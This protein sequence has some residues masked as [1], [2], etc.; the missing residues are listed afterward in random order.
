[1]KSFSIYTNSKIFN[2][3]AE[4]ELLIHKPF[5]KITSWYLSNLILLHKLHLHNFHLHRQVQIVP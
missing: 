4:T 3:V 1:M 5:L 2:Y